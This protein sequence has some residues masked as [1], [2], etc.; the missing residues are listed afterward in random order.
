MKDVKNANNKDQGKMIFKYLEPYIVL[1]ML[2]AGAVTCAMYAIDSMREGGMGYVLAFSL[3]LIIMLKAAHSVIR[4]YMD[5]I[6]DNHGVSRRLFHIKI[7]ELKWENID[8]IKIYD[9]TAT[10]QVN[11]TKTRKEKIY[12][13]EVFPRKSSFDLIYFGHKMVIGS[14]GNILAGGSF[15]KLVTGLNI[16]IDKHGIKVEST[17]NGAT[18]YPDRLPAND[19]FRGE[20]IKRV[21]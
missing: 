14:A 9:R 8:L 19:L 12:C 5:I 3:F 18:S 1:P 4:S 20:S 15:Y 2:I 21:A 10:F 7:K 11:Y 16:Y 17:L 13:I 6:I